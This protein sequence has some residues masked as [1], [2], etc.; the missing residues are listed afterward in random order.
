MPIRSFLRVPLTDHLRK[1]LEASGAFNEE[2]M[3]E[4]VKQKTLTGWASKV[5][6]VAVATVLE[7]FDSKGFGKWVDLKP[8]TWKRKKVKQILTE[9]GQLRNSITWDIK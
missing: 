8:E 1:K 9:T 5:A 7:A 3:L 2:A 6:V 4:V